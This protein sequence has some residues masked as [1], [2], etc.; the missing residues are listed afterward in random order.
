MQ[1][2]QKW[3][4]IIRIFFQIIFIVTPILG[5]I[6]SFSAAFPEQDVLIKQNLLKPFITENTPYGARIICVMISMIPFAIIM[7]GF[8]HLIKL[9]KL[10]E[11]GKIFDLESIEHMRMGAFTVL[12]WLIADMVIY[13]LDVLVLTINNPAGQRILSLHF[14][15]VHFSTLVVAIVFI[16]ITQ[17][18]DEARKLKDENDYIV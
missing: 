17:I 16:I 6:F 8:Y 4:R 5:F 10:Y 18:M 2:I 12:I 1:K 13:T 11:L 15:S 7:L 14:R 9:F 3:S